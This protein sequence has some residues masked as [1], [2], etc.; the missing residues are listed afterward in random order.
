MTYPRAER[1]K[2][3]SVEC[4]HDP[5]IQ[6]KHNSITLTGGPMFNRSEHGEEKIPLMG[7]K[8][9]KSPNM[10]EDGEY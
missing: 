10:N 6:S 9:H 5:H 8:K 2:L 1:K 3:M 4:H 7:G